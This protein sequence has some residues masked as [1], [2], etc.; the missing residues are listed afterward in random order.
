[1]CWIHTGRMEKGTFLLISS[2]ISLSPIGTMLSS[3]LVAYDKTGSAA[4]FG[5]TKGCFHWSPIF[6]TLSEWLVSQYW[7]LA[8]SGSGHLGVGQNM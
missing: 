2:S 1:M 5:P 8:P 7:T 6:N 3:Q 4:R